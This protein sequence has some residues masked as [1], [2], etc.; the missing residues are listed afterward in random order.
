MAGVRA[1]TDGHGVDVVLDNMGAK[2]LADHVGLL[3]LNGRLRVIGMQGG[4]RATLDLGAL[5]GKC[6]SVTA[7][8]LR[9]RPA[10]EKAAICRG[11]GEEVWPLLEAGTIRPTP[12][13][14]YPVEEVRAAHE[15]LESGDNVGKIVLV[16][17][18]PT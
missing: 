4:R 17:R 15:R 6:A 9:G 10:A 11:V 8:S 12:T 2:Y 1:A 5:L 18:Q 7:A 16:V 14:A 13:A 3:A